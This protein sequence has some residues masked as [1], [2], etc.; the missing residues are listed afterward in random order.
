M[1]DRNR[2]EVAGRR[3]RIRRGIESER[4]YLDC[5]SRRTETACSRAESS[6]VSVSER[7][8]RVRT[9]FFVLPRKTFRPGEQGRERTTVTALGLY[10]RL[11]VLCGLGILFEE[12]LP[13]PERRFRSSDLEQEPGC[14]TNRAEMSPDPDDRTYVCRRVRQAQT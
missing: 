5:S 2:S 8:D 10:G 7:G 12:D 1:R 6:L 3:V 11:D 9:P 4:G 14:A 13:C